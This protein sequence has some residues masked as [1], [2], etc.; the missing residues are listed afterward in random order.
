[1]T[2]YSIPTAVDAESALLTAASAAPAD[3]PNAVLLDELE[4]APGPS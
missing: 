4:G 2:R 3:F 1:M